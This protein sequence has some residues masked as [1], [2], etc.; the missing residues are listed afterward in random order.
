MKIKEILREHI[1]QK[2]YHCSRMENYDNIL[3]NGL[4]PNMPSEHE[5][6]DGGIYLFKYIDSAEEWIEEQM[7]PYT[8]TAIDIWEIIPPKDIILIKDEHEDLEGMGSYVTYDPI[9]PEFI[10]HLSRHKVSFY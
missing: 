6:S 2:Y 9:P 8:K 3:E 7:L 5:A 1:E 10:R 4:L